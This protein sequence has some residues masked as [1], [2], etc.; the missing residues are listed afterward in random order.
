MQAM[1]GSLLSL[2]KGQR[3]SPEE[4][5]ERLFNV[6]DPKNAVRFGLQGAGSNELDMSTYSMAMTCLST[7]W[8]YNMLCQPFDIGMRPWKGTKWFYT[9]RSPGRLLDAPLR[10]HSEAGEDSAPGMAPKPRRW[11]REASLLYAYKTPDGKQEDF[12]EKDMT[13]EMSPRHPGDDEKDDV[14]VPEPRRV[15]P[16]FH[17]VTT[18]AAMGLYQIHF[19]TPG[20]EATGKL[21]SAYP[22]QL[23]VRVD[24]ARK[25]LIYGACD[26]LP[27]LV[28]DFYSVTQRRAR[29]V[30]E[31]WNRLTSDPDVDRSP[32]AFT[33]QHIMMRRT[34]SRGL[35]RT[36]S[37][38]WEAPTPDKPTR[39]IELASPVARE[40]IAKREISPWEAARGDFATCEHW[41]PGATASRA[42]RH[43]LYGE[44]AELRELPLYLL[45]ICPELKAMYNAPENALCPKAAGAAVCLAP[46]G[47]PSAAMG[48]AGRRAEGALPWQ[49]GVI[50]GL[51]WWQRWYEKLISNPAL[52]GA[53]NPYLTPLASISDRQ[54]G[55][56]ADFV[57]V[58]G[59]VS[60][61][62]LLV[63]GVMQ[64][65][66][67]MG[68]LHHDSFGDGT[69]D[70]SA[71]D[72]SEMEPVE[73]KMWMDAFLGA[74]SG[75][76]SDSG[77]ISESDSG[78]DVSG[79]VESTEGLM[80][81]NAILA[82][83]HE[84]EEEEEEGEGEE[85]EEEEALRNRAT[86]AAPSFAI[87]TSAPAPMRA[88]MGFP[89]GGSAPPPNG[90]APESPLQGPARW[91]GAVNP[92]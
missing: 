46:S 83:G 56:M 42:T 49:W 62:P 26:H 30:T 85:E 66:D 86:A 33:P 78:S 48:A 5:Q 6:Q 81:M 74:G 59:R 52:G 87:G 55:D 11:A 90:D 63:M 41:T 39:P 17:A 71:S 29:D 51:A 79:D 15:N 12:L 27:E 16:R 73:A 68:F 58:Q 77:S 88:S 60:I 4:M 61:P 9:T 92:T 36:R 32:A 47:A 54:F 23:C 75:S 89:F 80:W 8:Q 2:M 69:S 35:R 22:S 28:L 45:E 34:Y 76:D 1:I 3:V 19:V 82:A 40:G 10:Y 43:Y 38:G 91:L 18:K 53:Y 31:A 13:V 65:C 70:D 72:D 24:P 21:V 25:M 44:P 50:P 37:I 57:R 7:C 67:T 14:P 84:E 20:G 64:V